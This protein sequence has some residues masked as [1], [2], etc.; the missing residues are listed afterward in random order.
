MNLTVSKRNNVR[1]LGHGEKVLVFAHGF[2]CDQ[3]I[4]DNI[5]PAFETK[6]RVVL[7]DYV[8]SGR[9]DK[10]AYSKERYGTLHGYKQDLIELCD[11]L[12]LKNIV[13]IG[14]SVSSMIGALAAI[15]RP[16]LIKNLIMIAPSAHYLNEPGYHGGFER[17]DIEGMLEM[18]ETDY[19]G[20]AKY[21]APVVLKN[22]DRPEFAEEFER[23]LCSNDPAIM[24][25]FA[26]ATFLS[27][28]RD[29]LQLVAVPTLI[30]QMQN[31]AI[32]PVE[33]V[34]FVHSRIRDSELVRIEG[35]GHNPHVSHSE[36]T[37]EKILDYLK[38]V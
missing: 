7:F 36:E 1:C 10:K 12:G 20:W 32:A 35:E 24:K 21:L 5:A 3:Y 28:V 29:D 4:W 17:A 19:K 6:Y 38:K 31:D 2:G 34:A 13:F 25:Q 27:D 33:A 8:G 11:A 23:L 15:E 9:S 22:A 26:E 37:I 16:D 30:L 18:L 14:H